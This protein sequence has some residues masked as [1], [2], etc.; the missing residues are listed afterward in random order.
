METFFADDAC[1]TLTGHDAITLENQVNI[2]LKKLSSWFNKNRLTLNLDKTF[3]MIF[4]KTKTKY[5]FMLLMDEK[6]FKQTKS[7]KYLE[8]I[9]DEKLNWGPHLVVDK[10]FDGP[11]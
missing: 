4:T 3:F 9:F 6:Y 11:L 1:L 10:L 8:V 5:N 7:I 2:E